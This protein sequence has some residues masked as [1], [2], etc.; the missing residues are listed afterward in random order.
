[1]TNATANNYSHELPNNFYI[2]PDAL[3]VMLEVFVGPLDLLL[4]LIRKDNIDIL[5]IP[6][7]SITKQ[8][9]AYMEQMQDLHIELAAD[10]LEMAAMLAEIK[11]KMLLPRPK[12]E[13]DNETDPREELIRRLQEYELIKQAADNLNALPREGRDT[14]TV[15]AKVIRV[16]SIPDDITIAPE[17]LLHA[18]QNALKN[19]NLQSAHSIKKETITVRECMIRILHSLKVDEFVAATRFINGRDGKLGVVVT[20]IAILELLKSAAIDITQKSIFAPIY[21]RAAKC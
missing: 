19:C 21:I 15:A 1:M 12:T 7:A 2:P 6:V 13:V 17:E 20:F 10:Y 3:E 11:S 18:L 5:N 8:Y 9:M 16:N 14:S 4:H